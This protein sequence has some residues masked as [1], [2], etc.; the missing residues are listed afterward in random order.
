MKK[1]LA[2]AK[3]K[4]LGPSM[5]TGSTIKKAKALSMVDSLSVE[6]AGHVITALNNDN[7][8]PPE[9]EPRK[10]NSFIL[11]SDSYEALVGDQVYSNKLGVDLIFN[12]TFWVEL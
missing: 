6:D 3:I 4:A 5:L 2:Y 7:I 1:V 8:K 10:L 12:G 9:I 11:M